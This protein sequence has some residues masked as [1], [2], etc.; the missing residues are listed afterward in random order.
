MRDNECEDPNVRITDLVGTPELAKIDSARKS[1]GTGARP[2]CV[3]SREAPNPVLVALGTR[4]QLR[5]LWE[6][7]KTYSD[8]TPVHGQAASLS[9]EIGL[10]IGNLHAALQRRLNQKQF[11]RRLK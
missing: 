6:Y 11:K 4:G 5:A 8:N 9:H 3:P 2:P 10:Y 7:Y 1:S